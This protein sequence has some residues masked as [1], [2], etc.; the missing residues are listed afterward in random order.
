MQPGGIPLTPVPNTGNCWL[1]GTK[2]TPPKKSPQ[3]HRVPTSGRAA[4]P[5]A[6]GGWRGASRSHLPPH[7]PLVSMGTC[8][9]WQKGAKR[10]V[11]CRS[12]EPE[13]G[14][15][16]PL[17]SPGCALF[18]VLSPWWLCWCHTGSPPSFLHHI[19]EPGNQEASSLQA[20]LL[21]SGSLRGLR[22]IPWGY[23]DTA[24]T[25]PPS[26]S[27][28]MTGVEGSGH[29]LPCG[30]AGPGSSGGSRRGGACVGTSQAGKITGN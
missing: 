19:L 6:G 4:L 2:V 29:P 17:G 3:C 23:G 22:S 24:G 12:R 20:R 30:A 15:G 18:P 21:L 7:P 9:G 28:E 5:A 27:A 10:S 13:G 26:R 14:C 1:W 25:E 8:R 16:G 11:R